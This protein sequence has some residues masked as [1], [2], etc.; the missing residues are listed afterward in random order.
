[1]WSLVLWVNLFNGTQILDPATN[2]FIPNPSSGAGKAYG[3]LGV[4]SMYMYIVCFAASWGPVGWV[5]I[6]EIFPLRARG[7]GASVGSMSHWIWN[8]VIAKVWPYAAVMGA[9]QYAVFGGSTMLALVFVWFFIPET[10]GRSLEEMDEVFGAAPGSSLTE[11]EKRVLAELRGD[12]TKAHLLE[13]G[14]GGGH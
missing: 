3:V 1:M 7:K 9:W 12:P 4:L 6:A 11:E 14:K 2:T 5:Y 8:F 13:T 10:K